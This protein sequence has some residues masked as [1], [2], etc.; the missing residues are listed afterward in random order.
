MR[1]HAL[2]L[3][4]GETPEARG[5][6]YRRLFAEALGEEVVAELRAATNS[7]WAIGGERFKAQIAAKL[8]RRVTPLRPGRPPKPADNGDQLDLLPRNPL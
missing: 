7:G 4:L 3:A 5:Q 6:A 1:P 2:Y 8:R